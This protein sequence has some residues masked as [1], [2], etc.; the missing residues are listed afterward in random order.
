MTGEQA[1]GLQGAAALPKELR[2]AE[3]LEVIGA[4][5]ADI[6]IRLVRG[7]RGERYLVADWNVLT[8][9]GRH[10]VVR[11]RA[12]PSTKSVGQAMR[13]RLEAE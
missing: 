12:Y 5:E 9:N 2:R 10:I 13:Y 8:S 7:P 6:H 11:G 1:A 4:Q 3:K